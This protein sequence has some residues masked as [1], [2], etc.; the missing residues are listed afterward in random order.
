[1]LRR[2]LLSRINSPFSYSFPVV[3]IS[4]F[5][6]ERQLRDTEVNKILVQFL[7]YVIKKHVI[8]LSVGPNNQEHNCAKKIIELF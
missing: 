4:C 3:L 2:L 8:N 1:M 5:T 6:L 7:W